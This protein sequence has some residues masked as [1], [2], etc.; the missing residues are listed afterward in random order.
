M[1]GTQRGIQQERI[2]QLLEQIPVNSTISHE[3]FANY[4]LDNAIIAPPCKL[5][6]SVYFVYPVKGIVER[7]VKRFQLG[8][9]GLMFVTG[10]GATPIDELGKTVFLK[11][12]DAELALM[13]MKK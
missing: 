7:K 9:Y 4:L 1:A 5:G 10:A 11:I 8:S 12:E 13:E 3:E 6:D 2:I